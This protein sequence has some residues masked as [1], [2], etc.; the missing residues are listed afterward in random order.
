MKAVQ[1]TWERSGQSPQA[2]GSLDGAFDRGVKEGIAKSEDRLKQ[3]LKEKEVQICFFFT[4][5]AGVHYPI[6]QVP[7][8]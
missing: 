8:D 7:K 4:Q 1:K 5:G 2:K 6:T 3:A